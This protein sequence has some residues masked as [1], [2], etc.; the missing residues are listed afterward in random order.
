MSVLSHNDDLQDEILQE[1]GVLE[2]K[3]LHLSER[4]KTLEQSVKQLTRIIKAIA[5]DKNIPIETPVVETSAPDDGTE[6]CTIN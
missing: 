6:T 2:S 4:L 1:F 5:N 3:V